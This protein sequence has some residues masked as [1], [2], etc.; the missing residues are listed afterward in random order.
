MGR[1][2]IILV[3]SL[4]LVFAFLISQP[5]ITTHT[6][7]TEQENQL[8]FP[9]L[10]AS[11][12]S[13]AAIKIERKGLG[14]SI[15]LLQSQNGW[16]LKE[17][18]QYPLN[19]EK[20]NKLLEQLRTARYLSA[21]TA[22]EKNYPLL[23]VQS[24]KVDKTYKL[25]VCNN[26]QECLV[27]AHVGF[28]S[29]TQEKGTYLR[30]E[31]DSQSWLVD[32]TFEL[33]GITTD[34][35][36]KRLISVE[37]DM[38]ASIMIRQSG[39]E[40]LILKR[41]VTKDDAFSIA[42]K[43]E[44]EKEKTPGAQNLIASALILLQLEDVI[45]QNKIEIPDDAYQ[46]TFI[47]KSQGKIDVKVFQKGT[48]YYAAFKLAL[49]NEEEK[50]LIETAVTLEDWVFEIPSYKALMMMKKRDDFLL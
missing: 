46:V 25:E 32:Q 41:D 9:D 33:G 31:A 50:S 19:P 26:Q 3:A 18:Y 13:L 11:Q 1:T 37:R 17:K 5:S 2:S 40:P 16:K 28:S 35:L 47:L 29:L 7:H 14:N 27:D 20:I 12:A 4:C 42:N 48:R 38:I 24:G 39:S 21:K 44:D 23:G 15:N 36:D 22:L 30:L 6:K 49:K 8:V 10:T 45:P 34:W 43:G